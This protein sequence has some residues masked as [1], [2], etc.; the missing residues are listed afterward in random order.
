MSNIIFHT[1]SNVNVN[2]T[3][4]NV[5]S[6]QSVNKRKDVR[7]A[8]SNA[9]KRAKI[10]GFRFHDLRHTFASHLVKSGVDLLTVKE[11]LGHKSIDMTLRYVH[12][13][14]SHKQKAIESLRLIDGHYL[15]TLNM[16]SKEA[17]NVID[18]LS[19][20]AEVVK[21]VYALRSGRSVRKDV[22]VRV[23]PSALDNFDS[24][25]LIT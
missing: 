19:R 20:D 22:G 4:T 16:S 9:L 12:L 3:G 7:T 5:F 14:S 21:L 11:L 24:S 13:S 10:T 8:F 25:Q 1:P 6:S 15:D 18:C 17:D 23:P 2:V